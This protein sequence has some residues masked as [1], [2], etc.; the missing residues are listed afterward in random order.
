MIKYF[1][2]VKYILLL[3]LIIILLIYINYSKK[4]LTIKDV[5]N[6]MI[7]AHKEDGLIWGGNNL[8]KDNYLVL[9]VTCNKYDKD[10]I[11]IM[12]KTNNMYVLLN[13]DEDTDFYEERNILERDINKYLYLKDWN[14]IVTHNEDGEYGSNQHKTINNYVNKLLDN[15]E[16]LYYFNKYYL[17]EELVSNSYSLYKLR[18]NEISNKTKVLGLFNDLEYIKEFEHIIPYE[19]F[20]PY[21]EWGNNNE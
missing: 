6:L 13:Y 17:K 10:F 2:Y 16:H 15:K 4:E 19:E 7:I 9:C 3:I 5:N 1:K 8:I 18:D 14:K 20:I 12:N 11:N 21:N